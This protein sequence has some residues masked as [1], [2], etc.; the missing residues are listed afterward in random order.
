MESNTQKKEYHPPEVLEE[1]ELE[2]RAGSQDLFPDFKLEFSEDNFDQYLIYQKECIR[3]QIT[4]L[5]TYMVDIGDS[6][7]ICE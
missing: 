6:D 1:L 4:R 5:I 2:V 3:S 7:I